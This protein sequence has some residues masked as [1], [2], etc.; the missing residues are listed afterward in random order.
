MFWTKYVQEEVSFLFTKVTVI[1]KKQTESEAQATLK[2]ELTKPVEIFSYKIFRVIGEI[3]LIIV[4][5]SL[6]VSNT[7]SE[8]KN[9]TISKLHIDDD[10]EETRECNINTFCDSENKEIALLIVFEEYRI[11][12]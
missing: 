2:F 4:F 10:F 7:V 9:T 6:E 3:E 5:T 8:N 12:D 1:F 11:C